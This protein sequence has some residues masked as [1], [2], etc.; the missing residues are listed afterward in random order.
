METKNID[1][2]EIF[3]AGSWPG[4]GPNARC[5]FTEADLDDIVLAF[6]ATKDMLKPYMKI[7]H[8]DTQKLLERDA[9]PAAGWVEN[10]RRVGSKLVADFKHVPAKVYALIKAGG[11][12]RVSVEML[13]NIE[14]GGKKW[15]HSLSAVS[16]LGGATPA[17]TSLADI[18]ALYGLDVAETP[19]AYESKADA[20]VTVYDMEKEEETVTEE[21]KK[22]LSDLALSQKA[23]ADSQ[24]I[25]KTLTSEK[26]ALSTENAALKASVADVTAK[27]AAA[28]S[29]IKT[30]ERAKRDGEIKAKVDALVTEKKIVP[31]QKD[32][33]YTLL[34]NM[35]STGAKFTLGDKEY[36]G[37]EALIMAFVNSGEAVVPK[38]EDESVQGEKTKNDSVEAAQKYAS[39]NKVSLKEAMVTLSRQSD[40]ANDAE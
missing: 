12:R 2:V 32:F 19:T 30:V 24:E 4:S 17:V 1:G 38:T 40:S 13:G 3:A 15:R 31:A 26:E 8:S 21:M 39:E 25:V 11:Y 10:L 16:I 18:I 34:V 37:A 27:F 6:A 33:L 35:E 20:E 7:G 9:M 36:D 28:E 14:A 23:Y 5:T 29:A 22:A